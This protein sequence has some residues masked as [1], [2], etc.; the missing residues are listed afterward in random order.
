MTSSPQDSAT[1][2]P[3]AHNQVLLKFDNKSQEEI[4]EMAKE[5]ATSPSEI[6]NKAYYL[7]RLAQGRTVI[8]TEK[9]S[10]TK[11]TINEFEKTEKRIK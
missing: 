2:K 3:P 10:K 6:I 7:F 9:D 4:T 8:L 1:N 5:L 11:L